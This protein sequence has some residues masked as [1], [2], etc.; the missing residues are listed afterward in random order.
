MQSNTTP[1]VPIQHT[2]IHRSNS[3]IT[4]RLTRTSRVIPVILNR[5]QATQPTHRAPTQALATVVPR[6]SAE[7]QAMVAIQDRTAARVPP[8]ARTQGR[9]AIT[10]TATAGQAT[11]SSQT[12]P[13]PTA[14]IPL[15]LTQQL[16]PTRPLLHPTASY[17]SLT[18][19]GI[20]KT[21][22]LKT[23]APSLTASRLQRV[24]SHLLQS[25]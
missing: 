19:L 24:T 25:I 6:V 12:K 18:I 10:Q 13:P 16:I 20:S 21:L 11:L 14:A 2:T 7:P 3:H 9:Q 23:I 17:H 22:E 8:T 15:K 1:V 5:H 4:N